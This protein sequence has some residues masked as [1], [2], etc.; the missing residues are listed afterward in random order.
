ME[1]LLL[2][3]P[4]Q[5]YQILHLT[6]KHLIQQSHLVSTSFWDNSIYLIKHLLQ[7]KT[8]SSN[9]CKKLCNFQINIIIYNLPVFQIHLFILCFLIK[10]FF[11]LFWFKKKKKIQKKNPILSHMYCLICLKF[12]YSN[13]INGYCY[14]YFGFKASATFKYIVISDLKNVN[15][16]VLN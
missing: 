12:R 9:I 3:I 2:Y 7:F 5:N 1:K 15:Y 6:L 16:C 11:V 4:S 14:Y 8:F 13:C 10:V